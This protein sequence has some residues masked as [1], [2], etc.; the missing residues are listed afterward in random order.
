MGLR[1]SAGD[2]LLGGARKSPELASLRDSVAQHDSLRRRVMIGRL[3]HEQEQFYEFQ[4]D[5]VV[6]DDHL[7]ALSE[8]SSRR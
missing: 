7:G 4:L 8:C 6:P 5:E 3:K 2:L 1:H